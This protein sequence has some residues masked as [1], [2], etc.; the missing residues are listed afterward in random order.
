[1]RIIN[2]IYRSRRT[3]VVRVNRPKGGMAILKVLALPDPTDVDLARFQREYEFT[4]ELDGIPGVV[5]MGEMTRFNDQPAMEVEDCGGKSLAHHLRERKWEL[6][7]R[8]DLCRRIARLLQEVHR[9]GVIHKD[10]NPANIVWNP[11]SGEL[12]LIDFGL[13]VILESE[14]VEWMEPELLEGTLAYIA[15][16]Q[17]GRMN[18]ELDQRADLYSLGATFHRILA[19]TPPF[20]EGEANQLLH[21]HLARTPP[22]LHEVRPGIPPVLS[23]IVF[24]LLAKEAEDRYQSAT[25][26]AEDLDAIHDWLHSTRDFKPF[27]LGCKEEVRRILPPR[28]LVGRGEAI[29]R[30]RGILDGFFATGQAPWVLLSG[31]AGIGKSAL[32]R[33]V[34]L[35]VLERGGRFAQGKFEL[36]RRGIPYSA[37]VDLLGDLLRQRLEE[38]HEQLLA[39]K[40]HLLESVSGAG[41][42]L[43]NLLPE[44]EGVIGPQPM[45]QDIPFQE[46]PHRLRMVVE[47]YLSTFCAP[48]R[49]LLLFLD[50]L[51]W[52]DG[53][54]LT[55]LAAL[56]DSGRLRHLLWLGAFRSE[57]VAADHPL[58]VARA[59][60]EGLGGSVTSLDV[61]P[62]SLADMGQFLAAALRVE[63][64]T[65]RPLA[66]ICLEKSGG[67]PLH[68]LQLLHSLHGEGV[69]QP[70]GGQWRWDDKALQAVAVSDNVAGLLA[71]RLRHLSERGQALLV[72]AAA[73]GNH[74][75]LRRL[76]L[77]MANTPR[78][79]V[80]RL[81]E[82]LREGILTP[83]SGVHR[84]AGHMTRGEVYYRFAHDRLVQAS[85]DLVSPLEWQR[86]H[87][88]IARRMMAVIPPGERELHLFDIVH[89]FNQALPLL[90][91]PEERRTVAELNAS[92]ATKAMGSVAFDTALGFAQTALGLIE[93]EAEDGDELWLE[94][95]TLAAQC[96]FAMGQVAEFQRHAHKVTEGPWPLAQ[97]LPIHELVLYLLFVMS[98]EEF[99]A[100]CTQLLQ[101][102]QELVPA[103]V[104]NWQQRHRLFTDYRH[105]RAAIYERLP[106]IS[107]ETLD[108]AITTIARLSALGTYSYKDIALQFA[109]FLGPYIRCRGL[110]PQSVMFFANMVNGM[111]EEGR[112]AEGWKFLDLAHS[113]DFSRRDVEYDHI[114]HLFWSRMCILSGETPEQRLGDMQELFQRATTRGYPFLASNLSAFRIVLMFHFGYPLAQC[115]AGTLASLRLQQRH[116]NHVNAWG[117][118][119]IYLATMDRLEGEEDP[120]N[121]GDSPLPAPVPEVSSNPLI[122]MMHRGCSLSLLL[123]VGRWSDAC[124]WGDRF[125]QDIN[126]MKGY[127]WSAQFICFDT[128]AR[129]GLAP[130]LA[131]GEERR[132]LERAV[133]DQRKW[134]AALARIAAPSHG[135]H[136]LLVDA[137]RLGLQGRREAA[138]GKV[139][140]ALAFMAPMEGAW[141]ERFIACR[142]GVELNLALGRR[143]LARHYAH[144]AIT[145]CRRWGAKALERHFVQ[146]HPEWLALQ[147]HSFDQ[148]ALFSTASWSRREKMAQV[149]DFPSLL[150]AARVISGETR[151]EELVVRVLGHTLHNAGAE[152]GWMV[153]QEGERARVVAKGD[154]GEVVW[155]D[156][157][158]WLEEMEGMSPLLPPVARLVMRTQQET[159]LANALEVGHYQALEGVGPHTSVMGIPLIHRGEVVGALHL[160]NTLAAG[161]FSPARV[162]VVRI[163]GAQAAVSLMNARV[164]ADQARAAEEIR[165]YAALAETVREEEKQRLAAEMHDEL[166]GV[167]T[168]LKAHGEV[169]AQRTGEA[170]RVV[171]L[172]SE[173]IATVRR[174]SSSLHPRILE[175]TGLLAALRWL[176]DRVP[177]A[178]GVVCRVE[179][180]S[181]EWPLSPAGRLALFRI[182]QEG[183]T[184]ALRHAGASEIRIGLIHDGV[185]GVL[186][187]QDDGRG[188]DPMR[189]EGGEGLG[190]VGMRERARQLGG[191][192]EIRSGSA[193]GTRIVIRVPLVA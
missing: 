43:L 147:A 156:P 8:L 167:L 120:A 161:V 22:R 34:R 150:E 163:L 177:S 135:H 191:T 148:E 121:W 26:V 51:Q 10:V 144:E 137:G 82:P 9:R 16:E 48:D 47:G 111:I 193:P 62:L 188:M 35:P 20:G 180:E 149:V 130:T 88:E 44:L 81:E 168:T 92:A 54:S 159:V 119:H 123:L 108:P 142:M 162:E 69:L 116:S 38:S 192:L 60:W 152:R 37:L 146:R 17:T 94:L 24:K 170:G 52:A 109:Q 93:G 36:L 65:V 176:A 165:R 160:E 7:E 79:C 28:Q 186:T 115:R 183:I 63:E 125:K 179:M 132:A 178:H 164:L 172:A 95:H 166:G 114:Q 87:G 46:R 27:A 39:W 70:H 136:L 85:K 129:I 56:A 118:V 105:Q 169:L 53:A 42:V 154:T 126:P 139:E 29:G 76:A 75:S 143:R 25:G 18:R 31:P 14:R 133:A 158:P 72:R 140:D 1:M 145:A 102:C 107:G 73:L 131:E 117:Q 45:E 104:I 86:L 157:P 97:K 15:P 134:L 122:R 58:N 84:L 106:R 11:E 6:V 185:D 50:D 100:Y 127:D 3:M 32:A 187:I 55:L 77:A 5:R 175:H 61:L 80:R 89:H 23:E 138:L 78:E 103:D 96:A 171:E 49:P 174:I 155:L 173:A 151:L 13:S 41:G 101:N 2:S 184:N 124:T 99:T 40:E 19:G 4:H 67:N 59:T 21:A 66:A 68:A 33:E 91:S 128:L 98:G 110:F 90:S 112:L 83:E 57:E 12:R 71:G 153:L 182:V 74:F 64:E 113:F 181:V 30:L 141:P 189:L 190:L